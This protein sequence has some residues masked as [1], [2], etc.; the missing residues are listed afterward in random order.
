MAVRVCVDA[1]VLAAISPPLTSRVTWGQLHTLMG[2][3]LA[4]C[5]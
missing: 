2:L 1:A 4:K 3:G 5:A